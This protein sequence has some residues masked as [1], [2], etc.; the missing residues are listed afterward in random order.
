MEK[1]CSSGSW[2]CWLTH[3]HIHTPHTTKQALK[4]GHHTSST[5]PAAASARRIPSSSSTALAGQGQHPPT[6]APTPPPTASPAHAHAS[7]EAP[8]QIELVTATATAAPIPNPSDSSSSSNN[9]SKP[10]PTALTVLDSS[11]SHSA[12]ALASTPLGS[13]SKEPPTPAG[14]YN[15]DHAVFDIDLVEEVM[16]QERDTAGGRR[17]ACALLTGPGW[18]R[19]VMVAMIACLQSSQYYTHYVWVGGCVL[20]WSLWDGKRGAS[21]H[22]R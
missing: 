16:H 10:R 21:H 5:A 6:A 19:V 11:L 15:P 4:G 22:I 7:S 1:Q 17:N 18:K 20:G 14:F 13:S 3:T 9:R 12:S 2:G 8:G